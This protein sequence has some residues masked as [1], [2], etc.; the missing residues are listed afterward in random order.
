MSKAEPGRLQ[1]MTSFGISQET[2]KGRL[3]LFASWWGIWLLV[4]GV[5]FMLVG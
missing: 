3:F 4:A 5:L 1:R 2:V